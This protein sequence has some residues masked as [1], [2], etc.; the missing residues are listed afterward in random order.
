[1]KHFTGF[2]YEFKHIFFHLTQKKC[3]ICSGG[4]N[5]FRWSETP[6]QNASVLFLSLGVPLPRTGQGKPPLGVRLIASLGC[7]LEEKRHL[8]QAT[9]Q[10]KVVYV[11]KLRR[12]S[13]IT[14]AVCSVASVVV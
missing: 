1:M 14:C 8:G 6:D 4:K 9:V 11:N 13:H 10:G 2:I 3:Y 5:F 7:S 12:Q